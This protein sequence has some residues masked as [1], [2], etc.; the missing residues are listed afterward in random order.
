MNAYINVSITS[1][2]STVLDVADGRIFV[3][4]LKRSTVKSKIC[5]ATS[6]LHIDSISVVGTTYRWRRASSASI[7]EN[8]TCRMV[9]KKLSQRERVLHC[10]YT[11]GAKW[12]RSW[13]RSTTRT[14][15]WGRHFRA[16]WTTTTTINCRRS[17]VANAIPFYMWACRRCVS[18]KYAV[19]RSTCTHRDLA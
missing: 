9:S 4:V 14:R 2:I 8:S 11:N 10:V 7:S 18:V 13:K 5:P 17:N 3:S 12:R 15:L 19:L 6:P 16:I 1:S